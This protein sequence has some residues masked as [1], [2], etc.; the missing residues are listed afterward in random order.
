[1]VEEGKL[2]SKILRIKIRR[3]WHYGSLR[4]RANAK[5]LGV[6]VGLGLISLCHA[7]GSGLKNLFESVKSEYKANAELITM[8]ENQRKVNAE[9]EHLVSNEI[10]AQIRNLAKSLMVARSD[11]LQASIDRLKDP[12][13][14]NSEIRRNFK[15]ATGNSQTSFHC[16]A[17]QCAADY[18]ALKAMGLEEIIPEDLKRASALCQNYI[19]NE[20]IKPF[21]YEIENSDKE[22]KKF[23]YEHNLSG[24]CLLFYPRDRKG[25]YHAVA[26]DMPKNGFLYNDSMDEILTSYANNERKNTP[27]NATSF[28]K[29]APGRK[30]IVIDKLEFFIAMIERHIEGK[31]L[32]EQTAFLYQGGAEE[33]IN[34]LQQVTN[35]KEK[36]LTASINASVCQFSEKNHNQR[37]KDGIYLLALLPLVAERKN[38]NDLLE[39]LA[40][41]DK[42]DSVMDKIEY[43]NM[44][45]GKKFSA[46][47]SALPLREQQQFM[48]A[49]RQEGVNQLG[50]MTDPNLAALSVF[51]SQ[52]EWLSTQVWHKVAPETKKTSL[53]EQGK[54]AEKTTVKR[55]VVNTAKIRSKA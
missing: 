25:N 17:T 15:D 14:R 52:Q 48:A 18:R 16:L 3:W 55:A 43:L 9:V 11:S 12:K 6:V 54:K 24:G 10:S 37:S 7:H 46:A 34:H 31:T 30:A 8:V 45:N 49:L 40:Q 21:I 32:A 53:K 5:K 26:L 33:F 4:V 39:M 1:M 36:E 22:I 44:D 23:I 41:L 42:Q 38:S 29:K 27:V 2:G 28:R 47:L 20:H 19:K 13:I 35:L 51:K 50:I